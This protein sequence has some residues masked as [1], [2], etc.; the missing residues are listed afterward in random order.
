[1]YESFQSRVKRQ[2]INSTTFLHNFRLRQSRFVVH[3]THQNLHRKPMALLS[4]VCFHLYFHPVVQN[5]RKKRLFCRSALKPWLAKTK[6][7]FLQKHA[8]HSEKIPHNFGVCGQ[9]TAKLGKNVLGPLKCFNASDPH[10]ATQQVGRTLRPL[11]VFNPG[12]Q[13]K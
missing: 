13:T 12:M 10:P 1:M 6:L 9:H 2:R 5:F 11:G 3:A 4:T 7:V 8:Y